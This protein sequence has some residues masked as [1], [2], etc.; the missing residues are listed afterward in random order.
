[1]AYSIYFE[2][3]ALRKLKKFDKNTQMRL[4][5]K[6]FALA[7]NPRPHGFKKLQGYED[8][9]RI[10]VGDYIRPQRF[11]KPLRS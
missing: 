2:P 4:K 3:V 8:T 6:I 1:M 9:Y 7:E 5:S 11:L 10:R